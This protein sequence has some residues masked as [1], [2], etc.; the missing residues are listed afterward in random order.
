MSLIVERAEVWAAS[1]E[2]KAGA[3]GRKL[4]ALAE[5]GTDLDFIVSRRA[6]DK[7]GA[8][9]VFVT[10]IRGDKEIEAA[11]QL[12]FAVSNSMHSVRIE[13]DDTPGI[14]AE[15]SRKIGA[16]SISLRGVSAAVI[17]KRFVMYLAF[18]S[19]PDAQKAMRVLER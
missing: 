14:A 17:G 11:A 4:T 16:A 15:M 7:P 2:D 19:E 6:P 8:G 9:V 13:G 3:L 18:D 5:A 12:G 10:P 1:L